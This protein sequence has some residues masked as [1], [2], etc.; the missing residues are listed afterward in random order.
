MTGKAL[1][2]DV[3]FHWRTDFDYSWTG[4]WRDEPGGRPAERNMIVVIPGRDR[5]GR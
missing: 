1:A 4:G 5:R 2:G 3:P